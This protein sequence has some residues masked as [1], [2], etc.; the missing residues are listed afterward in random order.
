MDQFFWSR[1]P[2]RLDQWSLTFF[3]YL[4]LFY[5]T[6]LPDLPPKHSL[7]LFAYTDEINELL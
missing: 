5:R 7:M 4:T 6:R 2:K 1:G 3:T